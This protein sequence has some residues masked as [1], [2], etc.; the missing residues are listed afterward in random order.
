VPWT[1]VAADNRG[2]AGVLIPNH[3][4]GVYEVRHAERDRQERIY[5]G[6]AGD[7]RLRVRQG[8]VKGKLPHSGGHRIRELE[9][10]SQLVVRWAVTDTQQLTPI[11][12]S[13]TVPL[14]FISVGHH[15]CRW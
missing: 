9:D 10:V 14:R 4:S 1:Y 13:D 2:G 8:L 7:L 6:K 12:V 15:P 11:R 5:I 3:A